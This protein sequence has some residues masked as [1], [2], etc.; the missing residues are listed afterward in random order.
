MLILSIAVFVATL[1]MP[2]LVLPARAPAV[3]HAAE[4]GRGCEKRSSGGGRAWES[5]P[6]IVQFG[7]KVRSQDR[8]LSTLAA[9]PMWGVECDQPFGWRFAPGEAVG[10]IPVCCKTKLGD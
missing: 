6:T 10:L 7:R 3:R 5:Q 2:V 4:A 1:A 8:Q 9:R